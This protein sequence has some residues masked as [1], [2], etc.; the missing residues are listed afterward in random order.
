MRYI[1]DQFYTNVQVLEEKVNRLRDQLSGGDDSIVGEDSVQRGMGED[2][3]EEVE[4]RVDIM[5]Q[6][7]KMMGDMMDKANEYHEE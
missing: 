2:K 5:V 6:E 7:V 1:K 3:Q 4:K